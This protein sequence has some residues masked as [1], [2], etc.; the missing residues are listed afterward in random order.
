VKSNFQKNEIEKPTQAPS[1][2]ECWT[3]YQQS[4]MGCAMLGPF[5]EPCIALATTAYFI[6]MASA[7]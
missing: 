5:A 3:I 6:C 1:A 7:N 4:L 2:A